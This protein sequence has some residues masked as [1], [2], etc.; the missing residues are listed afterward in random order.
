MFFMYNEDNKR[1]IENIK[2]T[3]AVEK[4]FLSTDELNVLEK[5]ANKEMTFDDAIQNVKTDILSRMV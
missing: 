2:T 3:M 5:C 4:H 1:I